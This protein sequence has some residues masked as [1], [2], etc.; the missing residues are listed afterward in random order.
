M[1]AETAA[2]IAPQSRLRLRLGV[3]LA[4]AAS[5]LF[6]G[7]V[8]QDIDFLGKTCSGESDCPSPYVCLAGTQPTCPLGSRSCCQAAPDAP[9]YYCSD[10][11]P[12]LDSYCV[13]TCHGEINTGSGQTGFR[14][15]YYEVAD[16]GL[17]GAKSISGRIKVRATDQKTMPPVGVAAPADSQRAILGR[18]AAAGATFCGDGGVPDGGR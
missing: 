14:L 15:D 16:G 5:S 12:I 4:I 11:K 1:L 17:P 7:C 2:T 9:S 13:S 10:A 18:W 3:G 8:I 6:A